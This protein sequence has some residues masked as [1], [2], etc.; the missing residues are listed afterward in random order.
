MRQSVQILFR[1]MIYLV[2]KFVAIQRRTFDGAEETA[3]NPIFDPTKS[4]TVNSDPVECTF[5][6]CTIPIKQSDV[7]G[8]VREWND[9]YKS[10]TMITFLDSKVY[11]SPGY[12]DSSGITQYDVIPDSCDILTANGVQY[13]MKSISPINPAGT[14]LGYI[15]EL[16]T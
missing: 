9:E 5:Y 2:H 15:L 12:T 13:T 11:L 7:D 10:G 3:G 1:I 4:V 8:K 16:R 6:G 14:I